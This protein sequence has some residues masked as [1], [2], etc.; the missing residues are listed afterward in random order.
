MLGE[1][2]VRKR[3]GGG[4]VIRGRFPYNRR[5]VLTDGGN[6]GRPV[7]EQFK[8]MA[9]K[10]RIDDETAEIHLLSGHDYNKPLASRL[11]RTLALT[12][13]AEALLFEATITEQVLQTSYA[14][15]VLALIGAGLAVGLSPGFRIPPKKTVPNAET[16]ED[17]PPS[18]GR[19]VIRTIHQALL[20][21]LSI[22]TL[23]AYSESEVEE[24]D[25]EDRVATLPLEKSGNVAGLRPGS[26]TIPGFLPS[27]RWRHV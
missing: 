24:M 14:A 15:D 16:F 9:F 8:P 2:E 1:L 27:Y 20:Y 3:K 7:K 25:E 11:T 17:E 13:T 10:F 22:V 18:E 4:R 12:D 26:I 21:E 6:K 23:P 5:A 19:A